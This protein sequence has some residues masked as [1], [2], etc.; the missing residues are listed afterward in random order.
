MDEARRRAR[1]TAA[2]A[3]LLATVAAALVLTPIFWFIG[4]LHFGFISGP[5]PTADMMAS[6]VVWTS[7]PGVLLFAYILRRYVRTVTSKKLGYARACVVAAA[8]LAPVQA[9]I[10]NVTLNQRGDDALVVIGALTLALTATVVLT[11]RLSEGRT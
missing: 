5:D 11:M 1:I 8:A 10:W 6:Y 7:A 9:A 4:L 2:T 3:A